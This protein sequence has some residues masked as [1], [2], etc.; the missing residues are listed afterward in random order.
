MASPRPRHEPR[1]KRGDRSGQSEPD[2]PPSRLGSTLADPQ[3]LSGFCRLSLTDDSVL[4]GQPRYRAFGDDRIIMLRV[5]RIPDS[6]RSMLLELSFNGIGHDMLIS[7]DGYALSRLARDE[8]SGLV[9]HGPF[10]DAKRE[11][12]MLLSEEELCFGEISYDHRLVAFFDILAWKHEIEF[13][14]DDPK[15]IARLAAAVRLF[16]AQIGAASESGARISTFSDNVVVSSP[17]DTNQL[18]W[19]LQGL[20]TIQL[21]LAVFGFWLRGAVC[22]GPIYHDDQIVF[23]PALNRAAALEKDSAIY[24]RIILDDCLKPYLPQQSDF[25]EIGDQSFLDPFRA[26]F[27]DRIQAT[28]PVQPEVLDKFN[29]LTSIDVS[30]V[31]AN[32]PGFV[33]ITNVVNRLN[34]ELISTDDPRCHSKLAWL[35][36]RIVA[37][38]GATITAADLPK[39]KA[40]EKALSAQKV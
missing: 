13:A 4:L 28:S 37:R 17:V 6:I 33:A 38:T 26:S 25:I 21:G 9:R 36:D 35:F 1:D 2:C 31:P 22:I 10:I 19:F 20:A 39:T 15:K 5:E 7:C 24:P 3:L 16:R 30:K 8:Y 11:H 14:G 29:A 40:L 23:G 18:V 34:A 27:W 12:L 32:V